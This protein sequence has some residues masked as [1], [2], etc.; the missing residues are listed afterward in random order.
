VFGLYSSLANLAFSSVAWS[1]GV[2]A[3]VGI[4]V[5]AGL[6]Y[7]LIERVLRAQGD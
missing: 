2:G 6:A 1:S 4:L 3:A 7:A 5:G